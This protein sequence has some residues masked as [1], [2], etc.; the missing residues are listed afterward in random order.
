[1]E[2]PQ[3]KSFI[4]QKRVTS[5]R[6]GPIS[7]LLRRATQLLSKK[8]S[9]WWRAV[10]NSVFNLT[11]PRFEPQISRSRDERV[12]IRPNGQ[13]KVLPTVRQ[14]CNISSKGTVLPGQNDTEMG[15]ANA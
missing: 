4:T 13:Q 1:M 11:G 14:R 7:A 6:A 10:G 3:L 5:W 9:Q 12:T 8:W 15:P 2:A